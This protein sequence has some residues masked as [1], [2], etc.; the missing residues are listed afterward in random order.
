MTSAT[1]AKPG[2]EGPRSPRS[3]GARPTIA[4]VD[5]DAL[6][7]NLRVL[8][9]LAG[10]ARVFPVVKA[11]AYG[12]GLLEVGRSLESHGA[13]GLCVALTEEGL[14]LREAGLELPL[15]VLN[16]VYGD[17]HAQV[18]ARGLTPV[19]FAEDQLIAFARAAAGRQVDVHL[20]V[21]TGMAR[22]GVPLRDVAALLGRAAGLTEIRIAGVRTHLSSADT[23]PDRTAVQLHRF[24]GALS[25]IR[26]RGHRP[27]VVHAANSAATLGVPAAGYDLVRPGIAI[28][29]VSPVRGAFT[30]LQPVL[31]L[32][33]RVLMVR[34][35]PKGE[36][37]GYD[38]SFRAAR[39]S[40][41]ATVPMGYGDGLLRSA[42]GAGEMLVRGQR[43]RIVGRVSMDL[44]TLDVTELPACEAGDAVTVIGA[45]GAGVLTADDLADA[46]GTIA[47]EVLTQISPRVPRSYVG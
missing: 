15:L 46:C 4:Q 22:L 29:G 28:Y 2:H 27:A 36:S 16:G 39:D 33:S 24:E 26:A 42:Q 45:Q 5:L 35:V 14:R 17:E 31:S 11:D 47:Y 43:C 20:K 38:A 18:L 25:T 19:V 44:I 3:Q 34:S 9:R 30:E 10:A 8:R 1:A 41:I 12:H 37:V 40:R 6:G 7:H 13:D 23:D 21:D 32:H